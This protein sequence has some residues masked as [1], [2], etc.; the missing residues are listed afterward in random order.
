MAVYHVVGDEV[1]S[2]RA[3]RGRPGGALVASDEDEA[4]TVTQ[5]EPIGLGRPLTIEIRHV[6]TGRFP[7][8][9][10]L[11]GGDKD[12]ALVSGVKDY[13]VFAASARAL[14]L[15]SRSV[16]ARA[17]LRGS[18]FEDGTP[19]ILYSPAVMADSLTLSIEFAIDSF[20]GEF[21]QQVSRSLKA[22]AG[23]P[24]MLP[25][26]GYLM[27]AGEVARIA[28][29]L[30]DGLFDGRPN[31]SITESINFDRPG[32][33]VATADFRILSLDP[34]LAGQ[35]RYKDEIGLVDASGAPYQGDEPYVVISLDGK[36]RPHLESF[37]PTIA[38]AAVLERFFAVKS[39]GSAAIDTLLESIKLGSDMRLRGQA[40]AL[41]TQIAAL[42]PGKDRDRLVLQR[43]AVVKNILSTELRPPPIQPAPQGDEEDGGTPALAAA[44][45]ADVDLD[46]DDDTHR[47]GGRIEDAKLRFPQKN[48]PAGINKTVKVNRR[49]GLTIFEGDIVLARDGVPR[50]RGSAIVGAQ[51]R[52]PNGVLIWDADPDAIELAKQAMAHWVERTGIRFKRKEGEEDFVQFK[53]LGASWSFVGRQGGMQEL[54][55]S[56]NCKVGSAVHEIGHALGLWHEQSRGDRD[57]HVS[58]RRDLVAPENRH[59]FD[60]HIEDGIDIGEYDFGSIMHY[61]ARAFSTTGEPTIVTVD[62]QPIGQRDGLSR[63]DIAA[64]AHIYPETD[65]GA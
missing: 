63:G 38:S 45:L 54:S 49:D 52:W 50:S 3:A 35:Y 24:L 53:R 34:L 47:G 9:G 29:D 20:P 16:K 2:D 65:G 39:G 10:G 13:S 62:G 31:F 30:G 36:A 4:G 12:I 51:F 7:K 21:V 32:S 40:E 19:V 14:N 64:I 25:F 57:R 6:Y 46:L 60:K 11:F 43:E 15:I 33:S 59:N 41:K 23:V 37:A 22:L 28:G 56:D 18:A 58:I 8:K 55:F 42:Q 26:S 44:G 27:G 5:F 1:V 48:T 61:S 17:S